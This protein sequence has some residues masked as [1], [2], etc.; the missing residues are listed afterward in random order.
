MYAIITGASSGIGLEIAK[1]LSDKYNLILV[2]RNLKRL[3]EIKDEL[4]CET[5]VES[6]DLSDIN[7]CHLLYDKYKSY[8]IDVLINSAGFGKIGYD[9]DIDTYIQEEMI[10]LNVLALYSLTHLFSKVVKSHILNIGSLAG[11][12]PG[13]KMANYYATKSY[14]ISLSRALNYECKKK[15]SRLR[16]STLCPG[17][18]KTDFNKV[19]KGDFKMK[20]LDK[21]KVAIKAIKGMYKG[22]TIIYPSFSNKMLAFFFKIIPHSLIHRMTYNIQNS[23]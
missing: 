12:I 13:P 17:P 2:S 8:D 9:S 10:R 22:K 19:A 7:N 21:K 1:I 23:K 6:L 11:F 16:I 5:I 4:N 18:V 15:K 14:V 20:G 3:N